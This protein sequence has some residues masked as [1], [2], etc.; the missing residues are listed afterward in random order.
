MNVE[1]LMQVAEKIKHE[2]SCLDMNVVHC[3]SVGC[4]GGWA[5]VL[6]G[7]VSPAEDLTDAAERLQLA[8]D[9]DDVEPYSDRPRK[10]EISR[11]FYVEGWPEEFQVAYDA[12]RKD[13]RGLVTVA[14]IEH[15]IK[16]KGAE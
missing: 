7:G 12:A 16:T 14:R 9:W 10:N 1:L 11:L 3:G 2:P 8:G 5:I 13:E 6:D 4:I 15:F